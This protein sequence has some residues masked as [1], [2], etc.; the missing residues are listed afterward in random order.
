MR[1]RH[2]QEDWRQCMKKTACCAIACSVGL[3]VMFVSC[4]IENEAVKIWGED[5]IPPVFLSLEVD[6]STQIRASFSAPVSVL[7]ASVLLNGPDGEEVRSSPAEWIPRE[8]GIP[9]Q[10]LC[11]TLEE[12]PSVGEKAIFSASVS[13]SSGNTL[14]MNVPFTGFNAKP[15][16]LRINE[17]RTAYSKP[18]V[19][20]IEFVVLQGGN[21]GGIEVGNAANTVRPVWEFPS[22]EVE[23]GDYVVYH[24]RSVEDGLIDEVS[25]ELVSP[26]TEARLDARDFWDNQAKAPLKPT[27][28][29]TVRERKGGSLQDVLVC[30]AAGVEAWPTEALASAAAEACESGIWQGGAQPAQAFCSAGMTATRTAGRNP[31]EQRSA[32]VEGWNDV[33]A[34]SWRIC[35]TSK[36]SPGTVNAAWSDPS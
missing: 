26:G 31:D 15:A 30:V 20:F 28:V 18:K 36:A 9:E 21:L 1:G 3:T 5:S 13:D 35:P 22:S 14:S 19:E 2:T 10:E 32:D 17:I 25:A 8:P 11:F 12:F 16:I 6:S 29:I 24:L 34:G 33:S 27:N 23:T 4:A 7:E